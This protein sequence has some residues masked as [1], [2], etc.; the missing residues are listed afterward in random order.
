MFQRLVISIVENKT[1][2][3][4]RTSLLLNRVYIIKSNKSTT[5]SFLFM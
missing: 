2:R 4:V 1:R 5:S 3:I